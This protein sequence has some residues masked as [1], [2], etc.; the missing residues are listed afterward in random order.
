MA[1]VMPMLA[2]GS[3]LMTIDA[4]SVFF[5][6]LAAIICWAI[7]H[8]GTSLA[9]FGLGLAIGMGVLAKF[10]NGVQLTCIAVLLLW[11]KKH[12]PLLVSRNMWV[13]GTSLL[14]AF[15]PII[16]WNLQ[17]GWIHVMALHSR[18]GVEG[19]FHLHPTELLRFVGEQFVV[20]S[21][22]FMAGIAVAAVALVWIRPGDERTGFLLSQYWPLYGVFIFFSLNRAGE[23]N[24]PAPALIT[25]IIF[26][27][28]FWQEL[29]KRRPMERWGI[30][31]AFALALAMTAVLHDTELLHLPPQLDP[32]RRAQGWADFADHV[33][34]ARLGRQANV[35]IGNH[36][37]QASMMAFYLPDRPVIYL[38]PEP[39]G[40]SQFTLWP[41]YHLRPDTRALFVTDSMEPPPKALQEEC[42][43]VE[44]VDDFWSHYHG[45]PMTHFRI[46]VCTR[47]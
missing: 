5:W 35:L 12:R 46:Y 42:T 20:V 9:W 7:L 15:T 10:T 4:L 32:L 14:L 6:A 30:A 18:S 45:R 33:Q 21:P 16:W 25:G 28:V 13:V 31:G 43:T 41:G 26:T 44:M 1:T 17:T 29:A 47:G 40:T 19:S 11:S 38:P 27:V 36:Y 8:R 34:R 22:L 24:W 2:V 23:A 37:S 39:Y 3:I